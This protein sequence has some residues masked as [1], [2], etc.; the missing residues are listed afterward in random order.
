MLLLVDD[1]LTF[2]TALSR[3]LAI[4]GYEI[5]CASNGAEAWD[6]LTRCP[7]LPELILLDLDM[8]ILDGWQFLAMRAKDPRLAKIPVVIISGS[9]RDDERG[10]LVGAAAMLAKPFRIEALLDLVEEF[11]PATNR[12]R[13][14]TRLRCNPSRARA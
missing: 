3:V 5:E 7:M 4:E 8:P 2:Q 1:D 14:L 6:W 12:S 9:E 13:K 11:G 10:R